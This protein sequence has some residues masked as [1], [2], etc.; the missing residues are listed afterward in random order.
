MK[1][2]KH[3]GRQR[4]TISPSEGAV[5]S[6]P[7]NSTSPGF[8]KKRRDQCKVMLGLVS[9]FLLMGQPFAAILASCAAV[10]C[11]KEGTLASSRNLKW[12]TLSMF[13][14]GASLTAT[15]MMNGHTMVDEE[16]AYGLK[17]CLWLGSKS[18]QSGWG[19]T[20]AFFLFSAWTA[21]P[22]NWHQ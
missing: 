22:E 1:N 2:S 8:N 18:I 14:F 11:I 21:K 15:I 19:I 9:G 6:S 7:A 13:S 5:S 16:K 3:K 17:I 4:G 10:M 20:L 12:M